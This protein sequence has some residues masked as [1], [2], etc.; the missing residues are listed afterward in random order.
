VAKQRKGKK[1][2]RTKLPPETKLPLTLSMQA[3]PLGR[4]YHISSLNHSVS[5][6]SINFV[7]ILS[8]FGNELIKH[9]L[10]EE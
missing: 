7:H 2:S 4:F 6:S 9:N 1:K 3:L 10:K 8:P 5:K